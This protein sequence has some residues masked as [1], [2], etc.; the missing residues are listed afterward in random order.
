MDSVKVIIDFVGFI[1]LTV[2]IITIVFASNVIILCASVLLHFLENK[3]RMACL[4]RILKGIVLYLVLVLPLYTVYLFCSLNMLGVESVVSEDFDYTVSLRYF[5]LNMFLPGRYRLIPYALLGI[6]LLG[7]FWTGA[8]SFF[9]ERKV[10]KGLERYAEEIF[11]P[12]FLEISQNVLRKSVKIKLYQSELV[13]SPFLWGIF[14]KR[15]YLP[16]EEFTQ[17]ERALIYHHEL[18]H[19][20]RHD[21]AFRR[22]LAC[23]CAVYWF[24]PGIYSLARY[25]TSANEMACDEAVLTE[26]S[27]EE[28]RFYALLL[29]RISVQDT[30][31]AC[32]AVSF[33]GFRSSML[34][35][36][37]RNMKWNKKKTKPILA[38][39]TALTIFILCPAM[40]YGASKGILELQDKAV[41]AIRGVTEE[42][43][44]AP[45]VVYEEYQK[46]YDLKEFEEIKSIV[47]NP[48]GSTDINA[49]IPAGGKQ[50][51]PFMYIEKGTEV[52]L[53]FSGEASD[54]YNA[55]LVN[56]RGISQ[57]VSSQGGRILSTITAKESGDYAIF[58]ENTGS[59]VLDVTGWVIIN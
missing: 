50:K 28:R 23:L 1:D 53:Y 51:F 59:S 47:L 21:Y 24:N 15:I 18:T 55:G 25:F 11:D 39:V 10:L 37:I 43:I 6:W 22:I 17:K 38:A 58:I 48:R 31:K 46:Q 4:S 13:P 33:T 44:D 34:E 32:D 35:R 12:D 52:L 27:N 26:R 40:T 57:S 45:Q 30:G 29:Y 5:T 3:M 2:I 49:T 42:K 20:R 36:R 7:V 56:E 9:R 41:S 8:I 19:C 16:A 54:T 14:R